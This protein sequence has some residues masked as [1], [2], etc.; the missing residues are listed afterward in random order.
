MT[1]ADAV[2]SEFPAKLPIVT[3]LHKATVINTKTNIFR[4]RI[5]II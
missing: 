5:N 2:V 4:G 3:P 1:V